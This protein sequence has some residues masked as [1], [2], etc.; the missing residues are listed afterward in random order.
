MMCKM[1]AGW[2]DE[3]RGLALGISAG[4][5]NGLGATFMPVLAGLML[6]P[7]GWRGPLWGWARW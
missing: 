2:F 6:G 4:V 1:V 3:K 5:G 7:W